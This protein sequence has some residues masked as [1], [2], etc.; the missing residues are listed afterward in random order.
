MSIINGHGFLVSESVI[1]VEA[2]VSSG[3]SPVSIDAHD[4]VGAGHLIL[5]E[6]NT[7]PVPEAPIGRGPPA[8]VH[9]SYFQ[10]HPE[11]QIS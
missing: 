3:L 4:D 10:S 9:I 2:G 8:E 5:P 6:A 11:S 7:E 1:A